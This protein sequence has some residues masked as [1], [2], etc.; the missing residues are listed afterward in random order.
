MMYALVT[1]D[2]VESYG[3]LPQSARRLDTNEWVLGLA[4][5]TT[6]LQ[7]ACGYYLVTT[8]PRPADTAD[9]TYDYSITLQAGIPT[10]T[11]TARPKTADEIAAATAQTNQASIVTN[12]QQDMVAIQA[13]IDD[14]NANINANPAARI[15]DMCRMLRRLGREALND[16]TGTT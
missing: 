1:N 9:T 3:S 10:E 2:T 8:T 13:I 5:A 4:D 11:W 16:Y 7:Q 14:T 15:K 6:T 12:L